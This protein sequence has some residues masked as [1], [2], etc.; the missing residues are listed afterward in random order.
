MDLNILVVRQHVGVDVDD[1]PSGDA[2]S[3]GAVWHVGIS[4]DH[5]LAT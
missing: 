4:S 1:V 2:G 5:V 3:H